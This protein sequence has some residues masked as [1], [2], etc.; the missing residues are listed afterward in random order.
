MKKKL[1]KLK[2]NKQTVQVLTKK[3]QNQVVGGGT[4]TCCECPAFTEGAENVCKSIGYC[5]V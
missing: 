4:C 2:L 1:K 5:M 3:E